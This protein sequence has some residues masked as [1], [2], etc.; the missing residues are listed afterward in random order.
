MHGPRQSLESHSQGVTGS[1]PLAS[2]RLVLTEGRDAGSMLGSPGGERRLRK[3]LE[4]FGC[5]CLPSSLG[6]QLR[7]KATTEGSHR[8]ATRGRGGEAS[9]GARH[10]GSSVKYRD[11]QSIM[12]EAEY[13]ER[14]G[15][16]WKGGEGADCS[17]P[18]AG[19]CSRVKAI[20]G[21]WERPCRRAPEQ[22]LEG[23]GPPDRHPVLRRDKLPQRAKSRAQRPWS[24][25][26]HRKDPIHAPRR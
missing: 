16:V 4:V 11:K 15:M 5:T 17:L 10:G 23:T 3:A 26:V 22:G 7:G 19:C 14:G 13:S 12:T 1:L 2:P 8:C 21:S 6:S 9:R 18:F 20:K 25:A 24:F